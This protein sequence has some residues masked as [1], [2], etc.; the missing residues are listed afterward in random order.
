MYHTSRTF[1]TEQEARTFIAGWRLGRTGSPPTIKLRLHSRDPHK[2]LIEMEALAPPGVPQDHACQWS[3]LVFPSFPHN[4]TTRCR[5]LDPRESFK[6]R[7]TD[8]KVPCRDSRTP[9]VQLHLRRG[10]R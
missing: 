9:L 1:E 10:S 3:S 5:S 7:F 8:A 2:V 6:W 4:K